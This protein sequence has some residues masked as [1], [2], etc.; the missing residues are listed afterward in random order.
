LSKIAIGSDLLLILL[1][2]LPYS[3]RYSICRFTKIVK[4]KS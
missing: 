4:V 2:N 1:I 3:I